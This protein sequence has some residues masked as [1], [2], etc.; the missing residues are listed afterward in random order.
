MVTAQLRHYADSVLLEWK[1][2]LNLDEGFYRQYMP[3]VPMSAK[4][5]RLKLNAGWDFSTGF[6]ANSTAYRGKLTPQA[7]TMVT[8]FDRPRCWR[9]GFKFYFYPGAK[10]PHHLAF[11]EL[12]QTITREYQVTDDPEEACILVPDL[13]RHI[14]VN[15]CPGSVP[16]FSQAPGWESHRAAAGAGDVWRWSV[17]PCRHSG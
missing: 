10:Y 3:K 2:I 17:Q 4:L 14:R 16:A 15:I 1:K 5:E 7:C 9:N 12:V 13:V 8:C 6:W 11:D